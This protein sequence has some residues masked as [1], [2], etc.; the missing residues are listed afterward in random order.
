MPWKSKTRYECRQACY[1]QEKL[2]EIRQQLI[3]ENLILRPIY[4]DIGYHLKSINTFQNKVNQFMNETNSY[5]SV[6]KLSRNSP[7]VSQNRLA[8][9]VERV[10]TTLNNL[11]HSKSI[12]ETQ[13]MAM[14]INRS[15]L[16]MHYLYFVS[17]IQTVCISYLFNLYPVNHSIQGV[18][19]TSIL[20]L[21]R[22]VLDEQYFI[23]N[24]KLYRQTAGSASDSSLTIPLVYIYL[25]YW[26]P[27]LL[28]DLINKNELFFRSEDELRTLLAM[29]NSQFPQP[30]W[31]ITRIGSTI[32]FRDILITNNN[33]V[34]R[35]RVYHE[36]IYDDYELLSSFP[37]IIQPPIMQ[38][39]WKWLRAA[40]LK[41]IRY[42]AN[43]EI[44]LHEL[45]EIKAQ[46]N[47]HKLPDSIFNVAYN[48]I[49]EDFGVPVVYEPFTRSPHDIMREH[50]FNYD[51][52][53]K[54]KN[55]ERRRQGK[56]EQQNIFH[57]PHIPNLDG[58]TIAK[59]EQE[60]N[61]I[62]YQN[63][64]DHRRMQHIS[65]KLLQHTS[66]SLSPNELLVKKRSDIDY[67][68]MSGYEKK[69]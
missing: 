67:L 58:S 57:L 33:G 30:I 47:L 50:V 45:E 56:R 14:K 26:Q 24:Y 48:E 54:A 62:L 16:L 20:E 61:T 10:E 28:E 60:L 31:N 44:Y 11:L 4:K 36:R 22:L 5:S 23:Y 53:R 13:Y 37:D 41:A 65:I 63:F 6:F 49:L 2:L 55:K 12:T 46:L 19:I 42:C 3:N 51:R 1:Y 38:D 25:F 27:D 9:I 7:T 64:G 17:D 68:T 39:I 34:L 66:S 8:D 18:T 29:T 69:K 59:I 43:Q 40:F 35:I 32:H 52:Y 21:V 15:K